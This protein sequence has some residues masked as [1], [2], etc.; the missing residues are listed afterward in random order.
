MFVRFI[1]CLLI[2]CGSIIAQ[3]NNQII[4]DSVVGKRA[5][6]I[7]L[8]GYIDTYYAYDFNKPSN[9]LISYFVSSNQHNQFALN[10]GYLDLT[11]TTNL[12]K[13]KI[14]PG[15][16]TYIESNYVNEKGIFKNV[17]EASLGIC[18]SSKRK[19]WLEAGVFGSPFTNE[20]AISKDQYMYTRSF[21]PE[22]VPYYLAGIKASYPINEKFNLYV[23]FLNGW[24]QIH[25][26]NKGKSIA[27]QLEYR[28]NEK[29]IINWNTYVGDER[30]SLQPHFRMRYF[31]DIYF[32]TKFNHKL[33]LIACVYGGIQRYTQLSNSDSE[34]GSLYWWQANVVGKW[35]LSQKQSVAARIEYFND[36]ANVMISNLYPTLP[37]HISSV[38]ICYNFQLI[39]NAL[40]RIDSRAIHGRKS[41]YE[42]NRQNTFILIGNLT[43]WF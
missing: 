28:P 42:N 39:K 31:S 30:S 7:K 26:Q 19:I 18:V 15:L 38:G 24:Q 33:S 43:F 37:I 11:Y 6:K 32:S 20:S 1:F 8:S 40:F 12:F 35:N 17:L 2:P 5:K 3:T 29:Q 34:K 13:V 25:D 27:T 9:G 41:I 4:V 16:G 36:P 21:A 23:Y 14:T 10:L 22:Y